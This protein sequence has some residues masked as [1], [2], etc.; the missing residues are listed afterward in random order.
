MTIHDASG[1]EIS[2]LRPTVAAGLN[3]VVWNLRYA[4]VV[5]PRPGAAV[6]QFGF[7][8]SGGRVQGPWVMPGEYTVRLAVGGTTR[9]QK[10][11]V[12]NDPRITLT[13]PAL[14]AWHDSLVALGGMIRTFAPRADAVA[15]LKARLDSLPAAQR[16]RTAVQMRELNDVAELAGEFRSRLTGLYN[17]MGN[18]AGAI[19]ADQRSQLAYY[20]EFLGRL[21]PRIG[22]VMR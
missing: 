11:R 6:Q 20:R 2:R 5:T 10:V 18:W 8:G 15:A 12:M 14:V 7:G 22:T 16:G 21:E 17:E 1:R 13:G 9:E 4:D 3:R 19:T